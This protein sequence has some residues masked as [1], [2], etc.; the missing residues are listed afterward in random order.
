MEILKDIF[1]KYSLNARAKPSL[2][3]I[4]PLIVIVL[5]WYPQ[6]RTIYSALLG[7][8]VTFGVIAFL[9]NYVASTGRYKESNLYQEWDGAP[10][11]IILRYS[12][13]TI[14][15]YTK[16]RYHTWL[17]NNIRE[18]SL[19]SRDDE[20]KDK[21]DADQKYESA[22]RFLREKTRDRSLY[23]LVF[24][25]NINYGFSRNIWA[26]KPIGISLSLF[27]LIM[28]SALIW[29]KIQPDIV[30]GNQNILRLMPVD[31][32][33]SWMISL[34]C[35]SAWIFWAKKEWVKNR[36]FAYA[37]ALLAVCDS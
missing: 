23:P 13:S 6:S 2:F 12:D 31:G 4:F 19:P 35:L 18:W 33:L 27:A 30:E 26:I 11:T 5:A 21:E 24:A 25:E 9:A 32:A 29:H 36:G 17:N 8:A 15:K 10:T 7:G 14:D 1:D 16:K 34:L 28:N 22:I 20:M 3:M 37:R